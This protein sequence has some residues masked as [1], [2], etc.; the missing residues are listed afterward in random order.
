MV[1]LGSIGLWI[2]MLGIFSVTGDFGWLGGTIL[3]LFAV[4]VI[5]RFFD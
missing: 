5:Q 3:F 1:I 4:S 2:I